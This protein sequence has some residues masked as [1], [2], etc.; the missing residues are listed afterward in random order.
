MAARFEAVII[1]KDALRGALLRSQEIVNLL[2]NTGKNAAEFTDFATGSRSPAKERV[3]SRFFVP[4]TTQ[5]D[6]NFITM[7]SALSYSP[8]GSV[9]RA[10]LFVYIICNEDQMDLEQG[11]RAD[12][13]ANEID[14][15]LNRPDSIFGLGGVRLIGSEET[16]FNNNFYGLTLTYA[17]NE[18][19][20]DAG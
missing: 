4:G 7:R 6:K 3:I 17:T 5:V 8:N 10:R 19:N 2:M 13:L 1:E 14:K 9:N 16:Q 18:H 12:L 20:R 11:S 15:I